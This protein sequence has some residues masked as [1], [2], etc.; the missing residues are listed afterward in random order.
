[1]S[2]SDRP[3]GTSTPFLRAAPHSGCVLGPLSPSL[4]KFPLISHVGSLSA[5]RI[6]KITP[7]ISFPRVFVPSLWATVPPARAQCWNPLFCPCAP[8]LFCLARSNQWTSR[9]N[10]PVGARPQAAFV[11]VRSLLSDAR[12]GPRGARHFPPP[13]SAREVPD[14]LFFY[15]AVSHL[16]A[17]FRRTCTPVVQTPPPLGKRFFYSP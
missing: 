12:S 11:R 4:G 17:P 2:M 7:T 10:V 6:A 3:L 13:P 16:S 1:V 15:R 5:F 9:T 8:G 14:L